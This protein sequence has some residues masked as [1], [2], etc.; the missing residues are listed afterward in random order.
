MD[1]TRVMYKIARINEVGFVLLALA[2]FAYSCRQKQSPEFVDTYHEISIKLDS[3]L[4]QLH[5]DGILNGEILITQGFRTIIHDYYGY[6]NFDSLTEFNAE[7][8][9]EV[10]SI[11]KPITAYAIAT[12]VSEHK[13]N[14]TD[15]VAKLLPRFPYE[16]ITIWHLL[17]HTSGLPD[18]LQVLYPVWDYNMVADNNDLYQ[19]LINSDHELLSN[20]GL[21]WNYSNIGYTLLAMII[22]K[23]SGYTYPEYCSANIFRPFGMDHTVI[24]KSSETSAM[25]NYVNDYIFSYGKATY[26]DVA[27]FPSFDNA[28]FTGDMYGAQGICTNAGDLLRFLVG[29]HFRSML[30]ADIQEVYLKPQGIPT[31]MSDDF[32]P[33]WFYEK[34][35]L[36]GDSYF[37]VGGFSGYRSLLQYYDGVDLS[38]ICLSNT[39][40][41]PI[42]ELKKLIK[43]ILAGTEAEYPKL[44]YVRE[45]SYHLNCLDNT[46]NSDWEIPIIDTSKYVFR[47][48]E[49]DE[50]ISD[51]E[52]AHKDDLAKAAKY[53]IS[54]VFPSK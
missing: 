17:T 18:Y 34:D 52:S 23:I 9:F 37:Y 43:N 35:S 2:M 40:T 22:E 24:P 8:I 12:L 30:S 49:M 15:T 48:Y 51:L 27:A 44:S 29:I 46:G 28:T 33:G 7:S 32:T 11:T 31:P 16:N 54:Q 19:I 4:R 5:S 50:L 6:S 10:A 25:K 53:Y 14:Y 20:P 21:N 3:T 39:S 26:M 42:W 1:A 41:T 45:I 47:Q 13:I 36:L 38:V